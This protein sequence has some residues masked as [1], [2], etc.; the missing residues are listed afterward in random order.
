[1]W[2][3]DSETAAKD[4]AT[5]EAIWIKLLDPSQHAGQG[6]LLREL[7]PGVTELFISGDNGNG[8]RHDL[9]FSPAHTH[10]HTDRHTL[11]PCSQGL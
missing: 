10:T 3:F 8:Y 9:S 6:S 1:M 2:F 7:F 11:T 5:S 4:A